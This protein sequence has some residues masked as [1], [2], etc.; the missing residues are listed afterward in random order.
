MWQRFAIAPMAL[1]LAVF[2]ATITVSAQM[3]ATAQPVAH[4]SAGPSPSSLLQ[5]ALSNVQST[6]ADLDISRW[7]T[8]R[9]MRSAT[10]EDIDSIQHDLNQ[11]LPGLLAPADAAPGSVPPTFAVYRN[12]DAL[13]DVL[14]RVSEVAVF[15]APG[16]EA[17][18][19]ASS[20][21]QL[22]E[23][24]SRLG[25]SILR[26]SQQ[27]EAQI[28]EYKEVIRAAKAAQAAPPKEIIINDGPAGTSETGRR[29]ERKTVRRKREEKKP[30]P[31]KPAP[32]TPKPTT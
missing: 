23:A 32:G 25:D 14:L 12:V 20:L 24:R 18:A 2:S 9:E 1:A 27:H 21:Q 7:R 19:I 10:Q 11:T 26:T 29:T 3:A 13:Y 8:S 16:D 6:T 4:T 30:A 5:Q 28:A 15:A 31:A 22:E 17:D